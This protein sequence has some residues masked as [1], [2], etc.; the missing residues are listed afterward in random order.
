MDDVVKNRLTE[1]ERV[2]FDK[3]S[4]YIDTELYFY[5]SIQRPDYVKGKSDIDIDIF[6][7]NDSSTIQKLCSFLHLKKGEFRKAVY[8]INNIMVYGYKT[9]YK[10]EKNNINVEIA[11]YND[12]YKSLVLY[13]HNNCRYLPLYV[14]I[15]LFIIKFLYYTLGIM[16]DKMYKRCKQ[17]LM[18][19]GD[20][21]KFILLD[22]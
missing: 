22:N 19:P 10:D 6:T 14:T 16:P 13:D 3:L 8:K 12:K 7:D 4:L 9:K 21:L 2:F 1:N 18:N 5:G 15:S 20:E 17:F 11:V